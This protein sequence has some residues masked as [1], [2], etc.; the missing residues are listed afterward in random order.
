M[1]KFNATDKDGNSLAFLITA[2]N[3]GDTFSID[4]NT[5]V[6]TTNKSLDRETIPRYNLT[7]T[8][9]D[10]AN[11]GGDGQSSS[12]NLSVIVTDVNDNA[13]RF[14]PDSYSVNVTENTKAGKMEGLE[15]NDS[16]RN[17]ASSYFKFRPQFFYQV[18]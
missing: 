12:K 11:G 10:A 1:V 17:C 9:T 14:H 15:R 18:R 8:V 6:L 2:G 13:P 16:T 7:V 5:G 4:K 3:T